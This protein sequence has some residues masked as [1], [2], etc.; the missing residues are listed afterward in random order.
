MPIEP[1]ITPPEPPPLPP[2]LDNGVPIGEG[3]HPTLTIGGPLGEGLGG[4]SGS[5]FYSQGVP[6]QPPIQ[7]P[8]M[9]KPI[10]PK[11][12]GA[13]KTL[14]TIMKALGITAIT[15]AGAFAGAI[16]IPNL[17]NTPTTCVIANCLPPVVPVA[18][19]VPVVPANTY[20]HFSCGKAAHFT[21]QS[22]QNQ[23]AMTI[24]YAYGVYPAYNTPMTLAD[25]QALV[26]RHY[27]MVPWDGTGGDWCSNSPAATRQ[28]TAGSWW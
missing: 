18:P 7:A 8:R 2:P 14:G 25:C 21:Y 24:G 11:T 10:P 17:V 20:L 15:A 13:G 1:V 22:A 5:S 27:G 26:R 3:G 16:I 19:V 12:G 9:P 4:Y 6:K 23:C 28:P